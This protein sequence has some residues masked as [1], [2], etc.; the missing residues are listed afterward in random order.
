MGFCCKVVVKKGGMAL[1]E[2]KVVDLVFIGHLTLDD[3][4][5]PSGKTHYDSLGGAA[6]YSAA[7]ANLW[8]NQVGLVSRIGTDYDPSYLQQLTKFGINTCGVTRHHVP[9]I[10]IWALYDRNGHRYFIPQK[11][12]G[13]YIDLAPVSNEIPST[14]MKTAKGYHIAPMPLPCQ[15]KIIEKLST[16]EA[17]ITIDP[18]HEWLEQ[19][20]HDRWKRLLEK[21]DIFLPSE[22][23]FMTFWGISRQDDPD[24]Y[25]DYIRR[26]ASLGPKIVVLKLGEKGA[27][28]YNK[29]KQVFYRVP[30]IAKNVVDVTGGGDAFCGG[31][32]SGYLQT[33]STLAAAMC[34]TVSS[35]FVIEDFGSLHMFHLE[36]A[37][38]QERLTNLETKVINFN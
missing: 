21:V 32:L 23:E 16:L 25:K 26:T 29:E 37:Q 5:L 3:T 8:S 22:D 38:I 6:L 35:S 14:Y 4:V 7:G 36:K 31:F 2:E 19:K 28:I 27:L 30:S 9:N 18:H 10:H 17:V 24:M 13:S 33:N 15:E 34:G 12:G 1:G 20:Y 11:G